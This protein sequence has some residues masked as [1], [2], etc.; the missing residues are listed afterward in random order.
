MLKS[1]G[2]LILAIAAL[3]A[4]AVGPA[5]AAIVNAK[6]GEIPGPEGGVIFGSLKSES[7]AVNDK[8][9][10]STSPPRRR[11]RYRTPGQNKKTCSS[12]VKE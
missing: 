6:I 10:T 12:A 3:L 5:S 1:S 4:L 11:L 7:V 2:L 8:T 9:A